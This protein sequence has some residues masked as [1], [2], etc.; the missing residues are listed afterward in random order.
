M[1]TKAYHRKLG[2]DSQSKIFRHCL[3]M[4]C[5][6]KLKILGISNTVYVLK[7][8]EIT[9]KIDNSVLLNC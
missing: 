5:Y 3:I 1:V 8:S 6:Q 2:L 9:L 7:R 4:R